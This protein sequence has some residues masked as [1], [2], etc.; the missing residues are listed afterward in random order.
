MINNKVTPLVSVIMCTYN[1]EDEILKQAVNSI[2][3]QTYKNI[4]LII[5]DDCS[6]KP[7][8]EVI[9]NPISIIHR[10]D[11][12]QGI[13][14]ARNIGFDL[15]HGKY[16][17]IMDA[18]DIAVK[19]RIEKQVKYMEEHDECDLCLGYM[20]TIE[21][22]KFVGNLIGKPIPDKK[23]TDIR[24][25]FQNIGMA[26]PTVMFRANYIKDNNIRYDESYKRNSDYR[27]WSQI[28]GKINTKVLDDTL[29]FYRTGSKKSI[30]KIDINDFEYENFDTQGDYFYDLFNKKYGDSKI[31]YVFSLNCVFA[32]KYE[33]KVLFNRIKEEN[34]TANKFDEKDL[35]KELSFQWLRYLIKVKLLNKK[36]LI[37]CI[38]DLET[39]KCL[40]PSHLLYIYNNHLF[41]KRHENIVKKNSVGLWEKYIKEN[42]YEV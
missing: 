39:I 15:S 4:E 28:I 8:S 30:K 5:I 20:Q 11:K 32:E 19:D 33:V 27:L 34:K 38:F 13:G 24:F 9:N 23:I 41:Q 25:L 17:A 37:N 6:K 22:G 2:Y 14:T 1:E 12:N 42:K 3:N 26:N 7:V 16:I 31:F 10:C 40:I 29:V 21:N 18:D 35:N 36:Y